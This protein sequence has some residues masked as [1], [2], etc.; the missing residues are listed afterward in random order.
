MPGFTRLTNAFS[1]KIQNH[2]AM[3]AIHVAFKRKEFQTEA[4]PNLRVYPFLTFE[5]QP[6]SSVNACGC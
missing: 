5:L 6:R 4:L 1:K 2:A 3:V